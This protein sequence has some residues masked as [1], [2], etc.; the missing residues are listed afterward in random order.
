MLMKALLA[1]GLLATA[2]APIEPA[3]GKVNIAIECIGDTCLVPTE[4]LA[5]MV[6]ANH[7]LAA[8]NAQ[9]RGQLAAGEKKCARIE[10]LPERRT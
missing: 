10:A 5:L 4:T 8:E 1:A 6:R 3:P 7:Q 9:L 2:A